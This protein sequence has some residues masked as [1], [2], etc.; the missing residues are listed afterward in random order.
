MH[1][2]TASLALL[3]SDYAANLYHEHRKANLPSLPLC[4]TVISLHIVGA[5]SQHPG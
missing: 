1:I 2:L 3:L 5:Q 4:Y